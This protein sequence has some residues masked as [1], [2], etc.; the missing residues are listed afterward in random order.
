LFEK[1]VEILEDDDEE[2]KMVKLISVL[3]FGLSLPLA[4]AH[5]GEHYD[6]EEI[7]SAIRA[8]N[9]QTDIAR[10][11]MADCSRSPEWIAREE[12]AIARRAATAERLRKER[13]LDNRMSLAFLR[14][15][16]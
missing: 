13:G 6:V 7:Q 11:T 3:A 5:P 9:F 10:R 16:Q 2:A 12:A 14:C 8:R 15:W 1:A 4:L